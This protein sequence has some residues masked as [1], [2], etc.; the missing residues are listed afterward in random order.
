MK[1]VRDEPTAEMG[2]PVHALLNKAERMIGKWDVRLYVRV[3]LDTRLYAFGFEGGLENSI[4][5][6]SL[7]LVSS[8]LGKGRLESGPARL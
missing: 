7:M 6:P 2:I 5:T 4:G 1:V 8:L 3:G